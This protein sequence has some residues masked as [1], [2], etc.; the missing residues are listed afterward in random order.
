MYFGPILYKEDRT[1]EM[2]NVN[3]CIEIFFGQYGKLFIKFL[4]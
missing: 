3:K 1:D 2:R 4:L